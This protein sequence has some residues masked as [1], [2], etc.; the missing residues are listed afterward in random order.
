MRSLSTPRSCIKIEAINGS[1]KFLNLVVPLM[2][3]YHGD[4]FQEKA[5]S[6]NEASIRQTFSFN[7][8]PD[9]IITS[10]QFSLHA[11]LKFKQDYAAARGAT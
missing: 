11:P 3:F 7:I 10:F 8:T 5:I 9:N 2:I 1:I 4:G 6:I